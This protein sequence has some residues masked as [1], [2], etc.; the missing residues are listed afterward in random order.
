MA[1]A[2]AVLLQF[3]A[4][5]WPFLLLLALI[6]YFG[7][8]T[9]YVLL[10]DSE[11]P[12]LAE[13]MKNSAVLVI[14]FVIAQILANLFAAVAFFV[15]LLAFGTFAPPALVVL[16][17]LALIVLVVYIMIKFTLIAPVIGI[18]RETNPDN[19]AETVLGLDQG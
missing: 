13:A 15:P 2:Q 8:M 11:R 7:M 14:T 16:V 6:Q 18:E 4:D 17:G 1:E 12:T 19:R 9:L 3:F 5:A 10:T